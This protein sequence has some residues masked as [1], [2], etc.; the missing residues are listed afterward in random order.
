MERNELTRVYTV[1]QEPTDAP[2]KYRLEM[3]LVAAKK[4]YHG[5][6]PSILAFSMVDV[7]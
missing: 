5:S 7:T 4:L 6:S 1:V 2:Q 3:R